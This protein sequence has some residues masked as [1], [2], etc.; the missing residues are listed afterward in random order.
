MAGSSTAT[1]T[2]AAR[3]STGIAAHVQ[4]SSGTTPKGMDSMR[5]VSAAAIQDPD[6]DSRRGRQGRFPAEQAEDIA[7]ERAERHVHRIPRRQ[8][9]DEEGDRG[10]P[11]EQR[12]AR[13]R[14][15]AM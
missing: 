1:A 3:K 12:T 7:R 11:Q 2:A 6:R 4:A 9:H 5:R 14:R 13:R 15:L 10:D 8:L